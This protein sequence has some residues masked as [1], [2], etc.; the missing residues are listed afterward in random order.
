[1]K[2]ISITTFVNLLFL[3][4]FISVT[5]SFIFFVEWDQE[6]YDQFKKERYTNIATTFTTE[7][8]RAPVMKHISSL[9]KHFQVKPVLNRSK[10]LAILKDAK[11]I[12]VQELYH[13]R[14]RIFLYNKTYYIYIQNYGYNLML[15]DISQKGLQSDLALILF[16]LISSILILLYI[17]L[18]KKLIPLRR[19][20]AQIEEF[21]NGNLNIK[22]GDYPED[23]IGL[24]AKSFKK[25]I[26]FINE[27]ID[28]KNLF[29]RNMMHELKTPITKGRILAET[30]NDIEDK[31]LLIKAFERMNEIISNLA[32]IEKLTLNTKKI[33]KVG[34]KLSNMIEDSK[35][36]LIY[37][38]DRPSIFEKYQDI[39]IFVDRE[40]FTIVLKNLIDNGIKFS[41]NRRVSVE[42]NN[43]HIIFISKGKELSRPLKEYI[44]PFLQEEKRNSGFGLGLY[45]V[46]NILKLHG[47]KLLYEHK[48]EH[49][50]FIIDIG[51]HNSK[52]L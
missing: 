40:L 38:Q 1:M 37:N 43:S 6:K 33:D 20:N 24:I 22:I 28:S 47:F 16:A 32:Q 42:V 52:F 46:D 9:F 44:E 48:K 25:S 50:R 31:R 49:N 35:N 39:E 3:F 21:A 15:E 8:Q 23:E 30:I 13:G 14:S 4:T 19:L 2:K 51:N 10:K 26:K 36:L 41:D 11:L 17:N 18:T 5:A 27:L 7:L 45:I 34:V 12:Y 29:M